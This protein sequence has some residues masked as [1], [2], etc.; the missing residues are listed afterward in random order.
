MRKLFYVRRSPSG[1]YY[2]LYRTRQHALDDSPVIVSFCWKLW[3]TIT[4]IYLPQQV[5]K[6]VYIDVSTTPR[7]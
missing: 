3:E 2:R 1:D 5:I 6:R 4:D 7:R